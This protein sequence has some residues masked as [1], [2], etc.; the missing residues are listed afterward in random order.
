M[1]LHRQCTNGPTRPLVSPLPVCRVRPIE[2]V[3][4]CAGCDIRDRNPE[5]HDDRPVTTM[6]K[7]SKRREILLS[8][9]AGGYLLAT[10]QPASALHCQNWQIIAT[11]PKVHR[12]TPHAKLIARRNAIV[13]WIGKATVAKGG[14]YEWPKS[15]R[16]DVRCWMPDRSHHQC[17]ASSYPC[18]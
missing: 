11:G 3:I 8:I 18:R 10:P 13:E 14:P 6:Q 17:S 5:A 7:T 16:Q 15:E 9:L 12:D 2:C 4:A 1:L